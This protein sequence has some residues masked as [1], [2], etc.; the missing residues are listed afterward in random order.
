VALGTELEALSRRVVKELF[1]SIHAEVRD[2]VNIPAEA[3]DTPLLLG[4]IRNNTSAGRPS[5][6]FEGEFLESDF[7]L[8]FVT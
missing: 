8:N 2:E 6:C 1:D 5:A 4:F 7:V 3:L